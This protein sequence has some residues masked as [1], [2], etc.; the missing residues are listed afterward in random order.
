MCIADALELEKIGASHVT[1]CNWMYKYAYMIS[2]YLGEMTHKP[3]DVN[4]RHVL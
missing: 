1:I 3:C 2:E 4:S